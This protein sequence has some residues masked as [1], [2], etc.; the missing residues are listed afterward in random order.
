MIFRDYLFFAFKNRSGYVNCE[1]TGMVTNVYSDEFRSATPLYLRLFSS[2]T[3]TQRTGRF[4]N[5]RTV[6]VVLP[7][8]ISSF[9]PGMK[10]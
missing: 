2:F 8:T 7:K 9:G 3:G 1:V 10:K 4:M 5:L 6:S